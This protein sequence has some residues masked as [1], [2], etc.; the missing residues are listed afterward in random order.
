MF[1]NKQTKKVVWIKFFFFCW[2]N[3]NG[4]VVVDG[5]FDDDDDGG[6]KRTKTNERRE[7]EKTCFVGQNLEQQ[8][9]MQCWFTR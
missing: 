6:A 5:D 2:A 4:D 9:C 7:S 8:P 3:D 1:Q